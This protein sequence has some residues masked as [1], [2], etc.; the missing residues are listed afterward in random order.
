[1]HEVLTRVALIAAFVL[2]ACAPIESTEA[3]PSLAGTNWT[4]AAMPDWTPGDSKRAPTLNFAE[5]RVSGHSGC[6]SFSGAYELKG[7]KLT[8]SNMAT[9]LMACD[10][11]M[12]VERLFHQMLGK[13]RTA[14]VTPDTL[15][16][17]G[18]G[19]AEVARF[20]RSSG[21]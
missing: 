5:S 3:A 8:F 2:A 15:I 19:G 1:M 10:V 18:E 11:G 4:L 7:A 17:M 12:N 14:S 16:L 13:V 20:T 6:N 9:T 21:S